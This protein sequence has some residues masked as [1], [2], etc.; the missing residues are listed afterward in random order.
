M[1]NRSQ[2]TSSKSLQNYGACASLAAS[3]K[4]CYARTHAQISHSQ[5]TCFEQNYRRVMDCNVFPCSVLSSLS[6][7]SMCVHL[8]SYK[9]QNVSSLSCML[10]C[11]T[12]DLV[13]SK[14]MS[15]TKRIE[16]AFVV[17][18]RCQAWYES[19]TTT[20][21]S[22]NSQKQLLRRQLQVE[23]RTS[24]LFHYLNSVGRRMCSNISW[25]PL[26]HVAQK[27][28]M[29]TTWIPSSLGSSLEFSSCICCSHW[30]A[31]QSAVPSAN[32]ALDLQTLGGEAQTLGGVE[33]PAP[34]PW[35]LPWLS[36][37]LQ[38]CLQAWQQQL[39]QP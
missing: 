38:A 7:H 5:P 36:T 6:L 31:E 18:G 26:S 30:A 24:K 39:Q 14:S 23:L 10:E 1:P 4:P 27:C 22:Y 32:R 11:I 3:W 16:Q 33:W 21:A 9:C 28:C 25:S 19:W 34:L 35:L 17:L 8:G 13:L 2:E 29:L 15:S 37:W 12:C 20:A